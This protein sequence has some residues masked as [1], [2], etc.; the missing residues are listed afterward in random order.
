[1]D[2]FSLD[3][4]GFKRPMIKLYGSPAIIDTGAV[5]P[6]TWLSPELLERAWDA[7]LILQNQDISDI[8]GKAYGNIYSLKDFNIGNL[9]FDNIEFFV[10]KERIS[11]YSF[12]LSATLFHGFKYDIDD[13]KNQKFIVHIPEGVSLHRNFEIISLEGQMYAQVDGVLIQDTEDIMP[14]IDNFSQ[15]E[16]LIVR[17]RRR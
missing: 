7:E 12:L 6:M 14:D 11:R 15:I 10:S 2:T 8:G 3:L 16:E 1:M 5:I 4:L 13:T 17:H 9:C